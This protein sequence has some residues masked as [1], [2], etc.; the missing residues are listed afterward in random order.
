MG[1]DWRGFHEVG[2]G[3]REEE[4]DEIPAGGA[5]GGTGGR[6]SSKAVTVALQLSYILYFNMLYMGLPWWLGW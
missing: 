3:R 2:S 5:V 6:Q 1:R 4:P